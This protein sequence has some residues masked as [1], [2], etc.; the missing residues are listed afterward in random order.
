RAFDTGEDLAISH[1]DST[2]ENAA[3]DAFLSPHLTGTEFA[4]GVEASQ[5]CACTG[6]A[7][8]TVISFSRTQHEVPAISARQ[9][10]ADQSFDLINL[11]SAISCY[12]IRRQSLRNGTTEGGQ[13]VGVLQS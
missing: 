10:R 5:L 13:L 4:I 6:T 9:R 12:A 11:V 1:R 8:R 2:F 3:Y 7:R